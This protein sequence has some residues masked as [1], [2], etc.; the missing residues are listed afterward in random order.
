MFNETKAINL[1][2]FIVHTTYKGAPKMDTHRST[3]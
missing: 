3:D 2:A 1:A